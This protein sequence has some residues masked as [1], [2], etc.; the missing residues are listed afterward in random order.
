M[1]T[2]K[3]QEQIERATTRLAQLKAREIIKTRQ[4]EARERQKARREDAHRKITLGGLVIAAE[5]DTWDPAQ[6]V[7]ALRHSA[8]YAT[9][10]PEIMG[11]WQA[12]GITYLEER[13]ALREGR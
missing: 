3:L 8:T 4:N 6:I 9:Q 2:T 5:V 12:Q 10:H 11:R 13:K 7:A 1:S